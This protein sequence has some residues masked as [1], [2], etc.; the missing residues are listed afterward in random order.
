MTRLLDT[1]K[2]TNLCHQIIELLIEQGPLNKEEIRER[3]CVAS[4]S[5]LDSALVNLSTAR[6][7]IKS[8]STTGSTYRMPILRPTAQTRE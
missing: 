7:V 8:Q 2:I 4:V 1:C 6:E 5:R 3:L